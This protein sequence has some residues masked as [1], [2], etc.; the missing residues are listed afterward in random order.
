MADEQVQE[1]KKLVKTGS[2]Y[3]IGSKNI[4]K[5]LR[6]NNIDQVWLSVNVA[7]DMKQDIMHYASLSGVMVSELA[8]TNEDLAIICKKQFPTSVIAKV[9]K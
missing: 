6:S 4:I 5:N 3:I 2:G 8:L 9:K 7:E 1:L